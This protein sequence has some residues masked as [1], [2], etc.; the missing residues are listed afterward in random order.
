MSMIV[1][2]RSFPEA[3]DFAEVQAMEDAVADCLAMRKVDFQYTL[4]SRDERRMVCFYE[5]P[6][7]EAVR[8]GQD[9]GGL[10]Y[11][12]IWPAQRFAGEGHL[13]V[14]PRRVH[15]VAQRV[16]PEP[17][18]LADYGDASAQAAD[19]LMR[20]RGRFLDGFLA[21]DGRVSVCHFEAIDAESI[22]QVNLE[23][24]LPFHHVWSGS[25]HLPG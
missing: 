20:H 15:V 25:L 14:Q 16:F 5:A 11:D 3:C 7:A 9:K 24:E 13:S 6:D 21:P 12:R 22:R 10:P 2:E 17:I 4:F 19:C 1:V 23:S 8:Y 18:T